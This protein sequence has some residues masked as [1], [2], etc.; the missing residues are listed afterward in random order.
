MTGPQSLEELEAT[1]RPDPNHHWVVPGAIQA[2]GKLV[3]L[4][5]RSTTDLVLAELAVSVATCTPFLGGYKPWFA[6][7]V[8][9]CTDDTYTMVHLIRRLLVG[10]QL[11]QSPAELKLL[12]ISDKEDDNSL[13]WENLDNIFKRTPPKLLLIDEPYRLITGK[14]YM[15]DLPRHCS[16]YAKKGATVIVANPNVRGDSWDSL[17]DAEL[18][19]NLD[20]V[21]NTLI[22]SSRARN[23]DDPIARAIVE[24]NRDDISFTVLPNKS[25]NDFEQRVWLALER[26]GPATIGAVRKRLDIEPAGRGFIRDTLDALTKKGLVRCNPAIKGHSGKAYSVWVAVH[27]FEV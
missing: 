5:S 7:G 22:L 14:G 12:P 1:V 20:T 13:F 19:T 26:K 17:W 18:N 16:A 8:I 21:Q 23:E 4:G 25:M 15:D 10:R 9:V 3:L 6:G 24:H 11:E 2:G 27:N